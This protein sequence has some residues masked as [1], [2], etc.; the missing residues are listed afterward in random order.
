MDYCGRLAE[1]LKISPITTLTKS[2]LSAKVLNGISWKKIDCI[3][4][5]STVTTDDTV[6][7]RK[8]KQS[9]ESQ[10][11]S[12]TVFTEQTYFPDINIENEFLSFSIKIVMKS[13]DKINIPRVKN[14]RAI[15]TL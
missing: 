10:Q 7:W 1:R 9:S 3:K 14:L 12:E 15:A 11:N 8:L 13:K 4:T 2:S 5:V 6:I